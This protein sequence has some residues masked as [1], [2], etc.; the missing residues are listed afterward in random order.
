[1]T[2]IFAPNRASP[3]AWMD[4]PANPM[5]AFRYALIQSDWFGLPAPVLEP[6]TGEQAAAA[7]A[8]VQDH[9]W[10]AGHTGHINPL[11]FTQ[12]CY[13][14]IRAAHE[15]WLCET[16]AASN[17]QRKRKAAAIRQMLLERDGPHCWLCG[18]EMGADATIEH[19]EARANGGTW[20]LE[21]LVLTH[22][23][24]NQSLGRLPVAAKEAAR[25]QLQKE[26]EA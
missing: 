24:C 16:P 9:Y 25:A 1:M 26:W 4:E 18:G 14:A 17:G 6:M 15:R 11:A 23:E 22:R 19:L 5:P 21:N 3:P 2:D 12:R 20:D 13:A 10:G 8:D 7:R